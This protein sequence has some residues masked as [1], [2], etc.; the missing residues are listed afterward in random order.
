MTLKKNIIALRQKKAL[1][2]M[3]GGKKAI[4]K[5][6]A[7]GKM[8]ARARILYLLDVNSF[9]EYDLFVEHAGKDFDMNKT[10]MV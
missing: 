3:G 7:M 9:H 8:T 5:Q 2:Q 1:V 4:E 6:A 10:E